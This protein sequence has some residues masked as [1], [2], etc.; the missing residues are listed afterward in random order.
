MTERFFGYMVAGPDGTHD[1]GVL[2]VGAGAEVLSEYEEHTRIISMLQPLGIALGVCER[3]LQSLEDLPATQRSRLSALGRPEAPIHLMGELLVEATSLVNAFLASTSAFVGQA[4]KRVATPIGSAPAFGVE[5]NRYRNELHLTSVGYRLLYD[6]RNYAQH[7]ALPLGG[8]TVE[9]TRSAATDSLLMEAGAHLNREEL[10]HSGFSWGPRLADLASQAPKI[11]LLP[12][13]KE[14]MACI[15]RLFVF[16][17]DRCSSDIEAAERY[18]GALRR[19]LRIPEGA[20]IFLF[21]SRGTPPH[22]PPSGGEIVPEGQLVWL[23]ASIRAARAGA[24]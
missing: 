5:W 7:Y 4:T 1:F 19:T 10:L 13:A 12:H 9:G 8:V 21:N 3:D 15:R 14:Y 6:L 2:P 18:L 20:T 22:T 16:I 17:A 24:W 23:L 11:D